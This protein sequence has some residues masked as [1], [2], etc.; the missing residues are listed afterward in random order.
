[1]NQVSGFIF[2]PAGDASDVFS[3]MSVLSSSGFNVLLRAKRF[4]QWWILKALKAEVYDDSTYQQLLQK[5]YDILTRL[6]HPNI[7][8]VESL[9]EVPG[10]G[11]CIVMEW[12]EGETL[13]KWLD[14]KH[15]GAER[16]QVARQLLSAVEYIHEQQIVHRDLKPSNMMIASNGGTLKVIDFGLSDADNYAILKTPAGTDGY[17]S[18]EQQHDSE[19]DVRNDIYSLGVILREMRLGL[20]W[21]LAAKRCL[22]PLAH[23]DPNVHTLRMRIQQFHRSL[24]ALSCL[25]A[26]FTIGMTGSIPYYQELMPRVMYDVVTRFTIGNLE[27]KS[28]GGGL[29]AVSAANEKDSVIEIPAT[30]AYQGMTYRVDEVEDSAFA[31]HPSLRRVVLPDNAHL[32]VMKHIFEGSKHLA[33]ISFR[34]K[35]PP[36]LGNDIWPVK[37]DEVVA[38]SLF[39]KLILYVPQGSIEVYRH[40]PWGSFSHIEEYE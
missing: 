11:R 19:P 28:W 33:S 40:S 26:F 12:I 13:D 34:S 3:D 27:Y 21:R 35:V 6:H 24:V 25:L 9:E 16:R 20:S 22:R 32:H 5:E 14:Q 1:M 17:V 31:N 10:F 38:D 4:G 18:P 15:T 37:I 23:R 8:R 30:V 2:S 39:S 7:V 29:V 36:V